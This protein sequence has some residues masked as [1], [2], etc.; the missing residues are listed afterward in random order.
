MGRNKGRQKCMQFNVEI[1]KIFSSCKS[2]TSSCPIILEFSL[3]RRVGVLFPPKHFFWQTLEDSECDQWPMGPLSE[4]KQSPPRVVE[5]AQPFISLIPKASFLPKSVW[6]YVGQTLQKGLS[7][8]L[9][10]WNRNLITKKVH[11]Y[12]YF[13]LSTWKS[14]IKFL[15]WQLW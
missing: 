11:D 4:R 6:K 15:F 8:E 10:S 13:R 12:S 9:A 2:L 5:Q 14:N 1:R 7:F 3:T